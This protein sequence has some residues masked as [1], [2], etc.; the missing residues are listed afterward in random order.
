MVARFLLLAS[1]ILF[2]AS[3]NPA[4]TTRQVVR[5]GE[6]KQSDDGQEATRLPEDM[7]IKMAIA[8]AEENH[9]KILQDVEK[10]SDL[11]SEIASDYTKHKKFSSDDLK[12][13]GTIE[14]L[15][16][17]ILT[18]AGGD[19][20]NAQSDSTEPIG[21]EQAIDKLNTTA[22][23]IRKEMTAETRFVVSA[24]VIANSNEVISLS[25]LIR[26]IKKTD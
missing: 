16:K 24:T 5:P 11:S 2:F 8:R 19:E 14:K 3:L 22:A 1:F 10:L 23:S 9:K 20:V 13:L 15:A 4:Q 26:R 6:T 7:R 17:R 18:H 25:R 21:M 12:K